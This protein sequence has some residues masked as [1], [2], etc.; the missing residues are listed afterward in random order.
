M[1]VHSGKFGVVDG[2]STVRNWSISDEQELQSYVASNTLFG[3]GRQPG[4]ESW[5]GSFQ[6]YGYLPGVMPGESFAFIGYQAPDDDVSGNGMRYSGTAV[7]SQLQ[8]N[9]NWGAGEIINSQVDFAGHLALTAASGAEITDSTFP[10]VPPV[11]VTKIEFAP[12]PDFDTFEEL[13]CLLTA[14]LTLQCALQAY[15]NSCT[16]VSN[17]L[18]TGQKAGPIDWT[19]SVT[20]Q[21]NS[22]PFTKGQQVALRLYVN[23]TEF[24]LLKWGRFQNYTGITVDRQT[25][26]IISQ[27]MNFGM[28][29][30]DTVAEEIGQIV[31]P[32]DSIWWPTPAPTTT[33]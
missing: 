2:E 31:L 3:T 32:D 15:S 9:W 21:D 17:R 24:F 22:R 20:S 10:S 18:W 5:N 14:Q 33:A 7:S 23:A 30:F 11:T 27:T 12:G 8:I 29:G 6:S 28:D 1:G 13:D 26:A 19:L 4:K 25:G 16:I